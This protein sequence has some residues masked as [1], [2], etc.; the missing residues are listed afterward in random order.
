MPMTGGCHVDRQESI[1]FGQS[2]LQANCASAQ[3]LHRS[4]VRQQYA[5]LNRLIRRVEKVPKRLRFPPDL[6]EAPYMRRLGLLMGFAGIAMVGACTDTAAP[7]KPASAYKIDLRFFGR[8][9]TA[10]EQT[11]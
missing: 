5:S 2:W 10:S 8:A 1:V 6:E 4:R 3:L 11:L 7:A 9:T